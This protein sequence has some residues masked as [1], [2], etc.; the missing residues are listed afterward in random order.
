M[1][2][3]YD[4]FIIFIYDILFS[5]FFHRIYIKISLIFYMIFLNL[6][7]YIFVIKNHNFLILQ[8]KKIQK[9]K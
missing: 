7:N 9:I 5:L 1:T 6:K 8:E 2:L 3:F 4:I